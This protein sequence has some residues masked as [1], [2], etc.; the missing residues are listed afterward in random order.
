MNW[1]FCMNSRHGRYSRSAAREK[2]LLIKVL[3]SQM[4]HASWWYYFSKFTEFM[5]TVRNNLEIFFVD[6]YPIIRSPKLTKY[7]LSDLLRV[8]KEE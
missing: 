3:K 4:V 8:E 2:H 5:D 7:N 6:P 1:F